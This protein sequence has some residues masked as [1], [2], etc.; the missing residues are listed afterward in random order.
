M[1]GFSLVRAYTSR[2]ARNAGVLGVIGLA[3]AAGAATHA[4]PS[5]D[6]FALTFSATTIADFDHTAAPLQVSGCQTSVEAQGYRTATFRSSRPTLVRFVAGKLQPVV[7]AGLKGTVMLSGT[8]TRNV[9][10]TSEPTHTV[11]PCAKTT[12]S[13]E[14]ARVTLSSAGRGAI[15]IQPPRVAL[16]RIHCPEE[17][18]EIVSLP[19]G[20][21]AGPL[22][23]SLAT[24]A[25][26]RATRL[27]L[28]ATARRTKNYGSPEAGYV[29]QRTAWKFTLVRRGR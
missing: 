28:T 15:R 3:S 25:N 27:T 5:P 11:E 8:N 12:R 20:P 21:A 22:Q 10:C 26:P 18:N 7:A 29:R 23:L 6:V 16:R 14:N 4:A 2:L 24:L 1:P 17:P 19:L 13:F 9:D